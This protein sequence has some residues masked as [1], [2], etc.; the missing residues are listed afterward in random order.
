MGTPDDPDDDHRPG[1][2]VWILPILAIL[3]VLGFLFFTIYGR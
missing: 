2:A 1:V 3:V